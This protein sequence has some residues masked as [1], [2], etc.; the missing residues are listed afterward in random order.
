MRDKTDRYIT[1]LNLVI[2]AA[3]AVGIYFGGLNARISALEHS[4]QEVKS[5]LLDHIAHTK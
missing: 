5:L 2:T 1:V 4:V 3:L